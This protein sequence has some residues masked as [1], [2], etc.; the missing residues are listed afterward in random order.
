MPEEPGD[1]DIAVFDSGSGLWV[2]EGKFDPLTYTPVKIGS[3]PGGTGVILGN[4]VTTTSGG[5]AVVGNTNTTTNGSNIV[6]GN[7]NT[8][9]GSI[10]LCNNAVVPSSS[11]Q[12]G[13]TTTALQETDMT[14]IENRGRTWQPTIIM[15]SAGPHFAA[16][17]VTGLVASTGFQISGTFTI[18]KNSTNEILTYRFADGYIQGNGQFVAPTV[19]EVYKA[20]GLTTIPITISIS[21]GQLLVNIANL[22]DFSGGDLWIG[23]GYLFLQ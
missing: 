9:D 18:R 8:V 5:N 23:F 2:A 1:G 22:P 17:N 20:A 6:V 16:G 7:N 10:A 21:F 4:S 13:G 3:N 19:T 11:I 14:F 15:N 12:I